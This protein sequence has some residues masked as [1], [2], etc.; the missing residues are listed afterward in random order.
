MGLLLK[1]I[2][3]FWEA[4]CGRHGSCSRQPQKFTEKKTH[5][6]KFRERNEGKQ[7]GMELVGS[8]SDLKVR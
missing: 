4:E 7:R 6:K 1:K 8:V 3:K 5:W 2:R